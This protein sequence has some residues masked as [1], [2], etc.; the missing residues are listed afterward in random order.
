MRQLSD[1]SELPFAIKIYR[2]T[3]S[4]NFHYYFSYSPFFPEE[5]SNRLLF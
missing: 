4:D 3:E 5:F 1:N 2:S